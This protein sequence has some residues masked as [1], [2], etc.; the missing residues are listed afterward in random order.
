MNKS[1]YFYIKEIFLNGSVVVFAT[2]VI[3]CILAAL[4]RW[5]DQ[6]AS[7]AETI[8]F[9]MSF[10]FDCSLTQKH[11]NVFHVS[12][13][14]SS[15]EWGYD[16]GLVSVLSQNELVLFTGLLECLCFCPVSVRVI[17]NCARLECVIWTKHFQ[18]SNP[19]LPHHHPPVPSL[20][21]ADKRDEAQKTLSA[22]L[23]TVLREYLK[24]GR[25]W[26][27]RA[28]GWVHW[29]PRTGWVWE[30][31]W[32]RIEPQHLKVSVLQSIWNIW[33]HSKHLSLVQPSTLK[34]QWK[35]RT[36]SFISKL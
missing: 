21:P 35:T 14:L 12:P 10:V 4:E 13:G 31:G 16:V 28:V 1:I 5:I 15:C 30:F 36:A 24:T 2:F 33:T 8:H 7:R 23:L 17:I 19:P 22:F 25:F 29:V 18:T 27:S 3:L 20:F 34:S 26:G 11:M 6:S 9:L 32:S